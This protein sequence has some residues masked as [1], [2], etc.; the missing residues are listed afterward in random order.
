MIIGPNPYKVVKTLGGKWFCEG[1]YQSGNRWDTEEE[2]N[3]EGA[4]L[5]SV[6]NTGYYAN[7]DQARLAVLERDV[8]NAYRCAKEDVPDYP[9]DDVPDKSCQASTAVWAC[10]QSYIGVTKACNDW[11][12]LFK[13]LAPT[14]FRELQEKA[15]ADWKWYDQL[16]KYL[17]ETEKAEEKAK[18]EAKANGS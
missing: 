11:R 2:A 12:R 7:V 9:W 14:Q 8:A 1:P 5:N 15:C 13:H 10:G 3:R 18:E 6:Y 17:E 16:I 4:L